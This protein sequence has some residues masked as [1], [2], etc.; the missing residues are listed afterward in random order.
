MDDLRIPYQRTGDLRHRRTILV[1]QRGK[2]RR[3]VRCD[4]VYRLARRR[5]LPRARTQPAESKRNRHH[6]ERGDPVQGTRTEMGIDLPARA[7]TR[8]GTRMGNARL[9]RIYPAQSR[10]PYRHDLQPVVE[11]RHRQQPHFGIRNGYLPATHLDRALRI[12]RRRQNVLLGLQQRIFGKPQSL[13]KLHPLVLRADDHALRHRTILPVAFLQRISRHHSPSSQQL[14]RTAEPEHQ[15]ATLRARGTGWRL[16]VQGCKPPVQ[17]H[18][19]S[20]LQ[21]PRPVGTLRS[22]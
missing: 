1:R 7:D 13:G 5:N 3:I 14:C 11:T 15:I 10:R 9:C 20:I 17:T 6:I 4:R 16:Y 19:R 18:R 21:A 22:G 8:P 12:R 2:Q